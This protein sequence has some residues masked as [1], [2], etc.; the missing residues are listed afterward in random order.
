MKMTFAIDCDEVL[1]SLLSNMI[2]LYNRE[3]NENIEY[4]D[5]KDFVVDVS[6]PK[7][8]E[9]TG[10]T[11]SQ[12][13][14]QD[15]ST[16]LFMESEALPKVKEAIEILKEFGDVIIVTYQ[17]TYKN[18]IETL[19]WLEKQGIFPDGI[20]FLKNKTLIHT[21]FFIDDNDWN[22]NGCN[23]LMGILI[24][25]PYNKDID[26]NELKEKSNC[27]KMYRYHSLY[28]FACSIKKITNVIKLAENGI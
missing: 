1:R 17:K 23:A 21:T 22:F 20:C 16:E 12:W 7:I 14:F 5:V 19:N 6:F 9:T 18:K 3:F 15:H 24:D 2:S 11:A 26:I 13:F 8:Q 4:D 28:E 10:I 25:A 27:K